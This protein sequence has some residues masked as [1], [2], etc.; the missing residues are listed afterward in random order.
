MGE[1]RSK[2][3]GHKREK[4]GNEGWSGDS[5]SGWEMGG[6]FRGDHPPKARLWPEGPGKGDKATSMQTGPLGPGRMESQR[7]LST[8]MFA[9]AV[10]FKAA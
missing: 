8:V 9:S 4:P 5:Y 10:S 2:E 1:A 7:A 6:R 3:I